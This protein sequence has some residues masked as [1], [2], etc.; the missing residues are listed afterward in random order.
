MPAIVRSRGRSGRN[1]LRMD[2]SGASRI[3]PDDSYFPLLEGRGKSLY[4]TEHELQ[5]CFAVSDAQV[6]QQR[7]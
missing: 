7:R 6:G 5:I 3:S 2:V 1:E 4:G